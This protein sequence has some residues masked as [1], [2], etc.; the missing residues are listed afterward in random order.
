MLLKRTKD[1]EYGARPSHLSVIRR[2][3]TGQGVIDSFAPFTSDQFR[4]ARQRGGTPV[5]IPAKNESADLPNTLLS[6]ATNTDKGE[7][8]YAVVVDNGSEDATADVARKMGAVVLE[9]PFGRKMAATKAAFD[10]AAENELPNLLFTDADTIVMPT[11]VQAMRYRLDRA[12]HGEGSAVFGNS[13]L[14][15]GEKVYV[16]AVLSAAKLARGI[17]NVLNDEIVPRGHNYGVQLD[18]EGRMQEEIHKLADDL[19][20][21]DDG[22]I[23]NALRDSG[24]NLVGTTSLSTMVITR[25]DRVNSLIERFSPDYWKNRTASYTREYDT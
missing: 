23:G 14:W 13:L 16:D 7:G 5:F 6:I 10:Y 15:Y 18:P 11:W 21:G 2:K 24:A 19:F 1:V 12:N 8:S 4:Y 3:K 25:N 22:H 20:A 17:R 9:V